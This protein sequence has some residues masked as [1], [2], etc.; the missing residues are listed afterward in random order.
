MNVSTI[1]IRSLFNYKIS[2]NKFVVF[3]CVY[4]MGFLQNMRLQN[5]DF[6]GFQVYLILQA[7]GFV[8]VYG[9]VYGR[10]WSL[11]NRR[12]LCSIFNTKN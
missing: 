12:Y 3:M 8:G 2:I 1:S 7:S 11:T 9:L 10:R 5:G 6:C 4:S